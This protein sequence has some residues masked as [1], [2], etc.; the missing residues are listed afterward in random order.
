[1][2]VYVIDTNGYT[3]YGTGVR[4][5]NRRILGGEGREEEMIIVKESRRDERRA[6]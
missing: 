5:G 1:M 3:G 4:L 2:K 6:V